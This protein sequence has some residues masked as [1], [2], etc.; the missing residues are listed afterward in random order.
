MP[1]VLI[2]VAVFACSAIT[3]ADDCP[4]WSAPRAA[5]EVSDLRQTLTR[6]DDHYHRQGVAL[7]DDEVY[8][9]ARQHL[10]HLQR[11]FALPQQDDPLASAGGPRPHPIPHTGLIKLDD[12]SD[13]RRWLDTR[14]DVWLQPKVDGVAVT[15]IYRGGTL[16]Q[17]ISRGNGVSGHDWSRHL[18][19]L[20][21]IHRTLPEPLDLVLHG[22]LYQRLDEHVQAR[23]GSVGAR[24]VVAG[25]LARKHLSASD[26]Q[27]IAL[28][29]WDWPQG[30]NEQALR[31]QRLAD[32]GF[33]DTLRFSVPV[34]G[35]DEVSR[36]RQHW[37]RRPLPFASD[38]VVLRQQHR[39]PA[40]RWQAR[41]PHWVAA[42]KYPFRT[43]LAQV[44][45]VRF[46]IGRSGRITPLALLQPVTL[47]D[48]R[49]SQ[50]SLGSL[51]RWQ[52]LD[53]RP[54]D[55]VHI[56]LAGLIIPR[57]EGVVLRA[58]ERVP[59]VQPDPAQFHPLSCWRVSDTC[60]EQ[61]VARLAW[62]SGKQGLNLPK[63]GAG[64]WRRLVDAGALHGLLD[65]LELDESRLRQIP[66]IG[67]ARAAHLSES[68][69]LARSRP[70]EQWLRA[71]GVPA[72]PTQAL[73]ADWH[74]LA[75]RTLSQ[76]RQQPGVSAQR[77]RQLHG[78]FSD[79]QVNALARQLADHQ[80]DGFGSVALRA[81]Q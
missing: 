38:G 63:L 21:G 59:V 36:W 41:A 25:W 48:R 9:Q 1:K 62:L 24:G 47:D 53:V 33:V 42:W 65:W 5:S 68:F 10:R 73:H 55:Q 18:P 26:A 50:V 77:A 17:L 16:E 44:R 8:D 39:P 46:S 45:D 14:R 22:E 67:L 80:V 71:L 31:Y 74:S 3:R 7:V 34:T 58:S 19:M 64:T 4:D 30:P 69:R 40:S 51:A 78:F 72:R 66:G 49:L 54:G 32:L 13:V 52:A 75:A 56:S 27:R 20:E 37:Y 79:E 29:V 12:E 76:W 57:F 28:F 15:L 81:A 35:L 61:F 11:C 60:R 70:F 43:V 23:A 2:V 6:W